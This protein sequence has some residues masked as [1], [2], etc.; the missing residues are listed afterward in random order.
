M[1][2]CENCGTQL[3][4]SDEFCIECGIKQ[5]SISDNVNLFCEECGTKFEIGDLFC[6][7]CRTPIIPQENGEN[8]YCEECGT[9]LEAGD[10][11]CQECGHIIDN[12]QLPR[13]LYDFEPDT[14]NVPYDR[15]MEE[16]PY[17]PADKLKTRRSKISTIICIAVVLI[18]IIL[19]VVFCLIYFGGDKETDTYNS[20]DILATTEATQTTSAT[21]PETTTQPTTE[22]TTQKATEPT[23]SVSDYVGC[24]YTKAND[25][26]LVIFAEGGNKIRFSLRYY[27]LDSVEDVSATLNDN[28]ANFED[29]T[30]GKKFSGNLTFE[31]SAVKVIIKESNHEYM[32][33]ETITFDSREYIMNDEEEPTTQA[34]T[35]SEHKSSSGNTASVEV[36]GITFAYATSYSD[37]YT[38]LTINSLDVQFAKSGS[39][40]TGGDEYTVRI[41]A[42]IT[43]TLGRDKYLAY[44]EY[45]SDGYLLGKYFLSQSRVDGKFKESHTLEVQNGATTRIVIDIAL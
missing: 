37:E 13:Q 23:V 42:E 15:Y 31:K 28:T 45:D 44:Y 41:D 24:W 40:Y 14:E 33:V 22:S 7:E 25:K 27:Y 43:D 16:S 18:V 38:T 5:D 6:Q 34:A 32:P 19:A 10:C 17:L 9:E 35:S 29:N 1:K 21:E 39:W 30:D 3:D 11:F 26:E 8:K 12:Y 2:Y 36:N 20:E 4:D